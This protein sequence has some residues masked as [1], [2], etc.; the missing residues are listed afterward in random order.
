M[1][2]RCF[3]KWKWFK[4][5][6]ASIVPQSIYVQKRGTFVKKITLAILLLSGLSW[7][8]GRSQPAESTIN[9]H[10]SSSSIDISGKQVLDVVID[11]KK[12]ELRSD[13]SI[14]LLLALGDYRAKV[15]R[16]DHPTA[17]DSSQVY[18][19]LFPDKTRPYVVVG[20]TE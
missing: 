8:G 19:F 2:R 15:V 18:E 3:F 10:V 20:Q 16:N 9:V 7:A 14:G 1:A 17:Y 12:Y 5:C 6:Q 4:P 11:G 13:L